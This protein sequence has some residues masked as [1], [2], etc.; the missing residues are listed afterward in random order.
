MGKI[1]EALQRAEEDRAKVGTAPAAG[2][3][4]AHRELDPPH[5]ESLRAK[6]S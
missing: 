6:G 3:V 5:I 2:A 1:H 4:A